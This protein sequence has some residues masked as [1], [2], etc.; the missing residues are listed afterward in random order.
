LGD[1]GFDDDTAVYVYRAF[2]SFLVG[3]LLLEVAALGVDPLVDESDDA[4][5]P[6]PH[7]RESL[8]GFPNLQRLAPKLREDH[9]EAEF[10][11]SLSSLVER[12]ERARDEGVVGQRTSLTDDT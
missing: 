12:L 4:A 1:Q 11:E 2:T 10:D 7:R 5:S 3:H 9:A 8:D 6:P